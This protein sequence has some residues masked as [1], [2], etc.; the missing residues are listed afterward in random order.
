VA[1]VRAAELTPWTRR[2]GA[3]GAAVAAV[4]GSP[5]LATERL[6][7]SYEPRRALFGGHRAA[8]RALNDVDLAAGR[9]QTLA[10]VGE[11]GC[12]KSTLAKVLAGIEIASEGRVTLDGVEV[13]GLGVDARGRELKRKLQMVFQNPDSTLNPSHTVGYAIGRALR[14]LRGRASAD[15][16]G[17]VGRLLEVVKL[18]PDIA[19]RTPRRL[20]GGEKQR[21]AI[22]RALAGDPDVIVADEPVSA[23]D[24][25]VQ[26]AIINL[27]TELQ[28]ARG[29]TLVFISHDLSVVRYLADHVAVMYLGTVAEFGG[30][31]R[32]FAPPFH[33]YTEALL[34]AVPVP[35]PDRQYSRI[36][37]EGAVPRATDWPRGCPF[38]TRCPRKVGAVCD[39]T[40]PPV[41][42][43]ADGHRIACHI[44][45]G[46]LAALQAALVE[47]S[48]DGR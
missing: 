17:D 43:L 41:Q 42:R 38:A 33:P 32:V 25:S 9:R 4:A 30:V 29:T 31:E 35:D 15:V 47:P 21:V 10:I 19:F 8:V 22:A 27:L 20:S 26:A 40:P 11:S 39:D 6:G 48:R 28:A 1:C 13:G 44:P 16:A 37:L 2:G 23:L 34:S 12:G 24:V 36:L 5:V 3:G 46:E 45:A 14:R 18:T 7:K